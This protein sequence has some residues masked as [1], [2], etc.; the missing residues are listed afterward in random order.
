MA[1]IGTYNLEKAQEQ[2]RDQDEDEDAS[3]GPAQPQSRNGSLVLL[4]IDDTKIDILQNLSTPSAILDVHFLPRHVPSGNF[5]TANSNGSFSLYELTGDEK[6]RPTTMVHIKTI[7]YFAEN[8]LVT[9]FAWHPERFMVGMT[10]SDGRVCLGV[11]DGGGDEEGNVLP[12]G[13]HSVEAW[14]LAFSRDAESVLSGGDDSALR[15]M[16]LSEEQEQQDHEGSGRGRVHQKTAR[17]WPWM[18][19]RIHGA[20]VTAILPLHRDNASSLIVTGSYDDRIRLLGVEPTGQRRVLADANLGG[21]V[22][23]IKLLEQRPRLPA[24]HGVDKWRAEP[25]PTEVL[26]LVSCMHAGAKVVKMKKEGDVWAFEVLAKMEEHQSMN[27]GSDAQSFVNRQ[28]KR[29][30][31][32]TSFYDRLLCLWRF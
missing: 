5:G 9:S 12:V 10:G 14:T 18:D 19:T 17:Y 4:R 23:R 16:D 29:T 6:Q 30:F 11:I 8:V 21:G 20:G 26:L 15:M 3:P 28:G 31:L 24:N 1:V 7:Q 2:E 13:K 27:Y 22:W 25:P 32:S